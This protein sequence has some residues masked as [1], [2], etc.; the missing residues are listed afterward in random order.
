MANIV[1]LH[2]KKKAEAA[3]EDDDGQD[4]YVGGA[5]QNGGSGLNVIDP[6]QASSSGDPMEELVAKAQAQGASGGEAGSGGAGKR[7]ITVYANGFTVDDGPLRDLEDPANKKFI[8]EMMQG[9]AP[10]P[11]RTLGH[12]RPHHA[13]PRRAIPYPAL[14][15][16]ARPAFLLVPSLGPVA[17][18]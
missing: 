7:T 3:A 4:F 14:L 6:S 9:C 17:D 10:T 18:I 15:H 13:R 16:L 2:D 11:P 8:M 5:G 12:A 1:G